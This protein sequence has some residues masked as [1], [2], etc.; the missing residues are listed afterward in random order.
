MVID[1]ILGKYPGRVPKFVKQYANMQEIMKLAIG[2]YNEE[3]KNGGF[4]CKEHSFNLK[5]EE[6]EKLEHFIN[7]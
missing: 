5:D 3:V 4:P 7:K 2:K 6:R 1:D